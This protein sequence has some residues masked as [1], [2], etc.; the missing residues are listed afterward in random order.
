MGNILV[1]PFRLPISLRQTILAALVIGVAMTVAVPMGQKLENG[2]TF[3]C[4]IPI[5]VPQKNV[6]NFV[7]NIDDESALKLS[8]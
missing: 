4:H 7:V 2:A 1:F 6:P 3:G 8:P 5:N